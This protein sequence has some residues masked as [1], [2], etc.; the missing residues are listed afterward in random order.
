MLLV[1]AAYGALAEVV[2]FTNGLLQSKYVCFEEL[3]QY[4]ISACGS[5]SRMLR[6]PPKLCLFAI[7]VRFAKNFRPSYAVECPTRTTSSA[8]FRLIA[9]TFAKVLSRSRRISLACESRAVAFYR[10]IV[11]IAHGFELVR[12]GFRTIPNT[13]K[14]KFIAGACG[15]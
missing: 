12:N 2:V 15:E 10:I 11:L 3:V 14:I 4:I 8:F 1:E 6:P 9:K 7:I 5:T 13:P